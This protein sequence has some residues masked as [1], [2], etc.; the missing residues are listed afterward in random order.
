MKKI[1]AIA[2]LS[3]LFTTSCLKEG[4]DQFYTTADPYVYQPA[5][6]TVIL[7]SRTLDVAQVGVWNVSDTAY[8]L[9]FKAVDS[10]GDFATTFFDTIHVFVAADTVG[11]G[12]RSPVWMEKIVGED[13]ECMGND[14]DDASNL[15]K[16][17]RSGNSG[18][19][20]HRLRWKVKMATDC[21]AGQDTLV[22]Q[23]N[24]TW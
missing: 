18:I 10:F 20:Y 11:N 15:I 5:T 3:G 4:S 21:F 7:G 2:L 24:L 22:Y 17:Y 23:G 8:N 14:V 9:K 16:V 13:E 6:G 12:F 1:F 19:V